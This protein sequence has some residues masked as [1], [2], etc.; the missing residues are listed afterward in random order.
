M[1]AMREPS[2]DQLHRLLKTHVAR[3]GHQNVD[4]IG[5]DNELVDIDFSRAHIGSKNID[6]ECRQASRLEE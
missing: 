1:K 4:M 6:K 5:H 3:N 2:F